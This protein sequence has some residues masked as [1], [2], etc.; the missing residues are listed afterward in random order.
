MRLRDLPHMLAARVVPALGSGYIRLVRRCVRWTW[1]GREEFDAVLA[2][3]KPLIFAF[4]H[5]RILL[6]PPLIEETPLHVKVLIS[7]NR[8]GEMISRTVGYFGASAIRGSSRDPR[9]A[10]KQKGGSMAAREAFEHLASGG[11]VAITPDG[12]RGPRMRAQLG[13][14]RIS[15]EAGVPILPCGASLRSGKVLRSWDRFILPLPWGRGSFALGP[16]IEPP[17]E[18]DGE[19]LEAYCRRIETVLTETTRLADSSIGCET[20]EPQPLRTP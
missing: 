11:I 5:G 15:M 1:H 18:G 2:S 3:R 6:M 16:L 14:A 13:I 17:K 10:G 19:T 7:N 20:P 8:D 4:W 12:P 9:K